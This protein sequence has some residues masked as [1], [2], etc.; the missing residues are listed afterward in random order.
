MRQAWTVRAAPFQL[1][2]GFD[3]LSASETDWLTVLMVGEEPRYPNQAFITSS[4]VMREPDAS[5]WTPSPSE[6]AAGTR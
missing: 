4:H 1:F 5:K 3:R 6:A 2:I